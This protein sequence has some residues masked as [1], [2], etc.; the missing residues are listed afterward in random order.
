[1]SSL[2]RTEFVNRKCG[3]R[4]STRELSSVF[5]KLIGSASIDARSASC[6]LQVLIA[7]EENLRILYFTCISYRSPQLAEPSSIGR[8]AWR[9]CRIKPALE[10]L[11]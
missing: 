2:K 1:M 3:A 4:T 11:R 9:G 7:M 6:R 8:P 10:K 5:L